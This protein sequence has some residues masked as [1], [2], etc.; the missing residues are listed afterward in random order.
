MT[1]SIDIKGNGEIV[2]GTNGIFLN[3]K[4]GKYHVCMPTG[5]IH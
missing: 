1:S 4:D 5:M 3:L 2:V